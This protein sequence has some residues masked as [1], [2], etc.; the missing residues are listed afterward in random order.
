MKE[1]KTIFHR[2]TFSFITKLMKV[3]ILALLGILVIS[4]CVDEYTI[5]QATTAEYEV[6]I[7]IEGRILKGDESVV[8][9][10]HTAPL[11]SEA[12]APDILN[13]QVYVI[14]QNGYRSEIAEFDI[15]E[16]C[17]VIDTRTLE[18]NTLYAVEATVDGE[19]YQSEFQPLLASPEISEVT[20]QENE[21][22][23]SIYVSTEAERTDSRHFMWSFEEDWEFQAEVDT[24]YRRN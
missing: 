18:D 2:D 14:G 21:N 13:A 16:D 8:F 12:E 24:R 9:I 11:N 22:S 7:A 5:P 23:V 17:Y 10:S 6:E 4:S 20:W 19:T 15:E 3:K 1:R